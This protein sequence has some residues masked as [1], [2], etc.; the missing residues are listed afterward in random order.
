MGAEGWRNDGAFFLWFRKACQANRQFARLRRRG[1]GGLW[2]QMFAR[3]LLSLA[4]FE[5]AIR[6][7]QARASLYRCIGLCPEGCLQMPPS[8]VRG[9]MLRVE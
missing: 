5:T 7:R 8:V 6:R 9:N 2:R 4:G 3:G 1:M